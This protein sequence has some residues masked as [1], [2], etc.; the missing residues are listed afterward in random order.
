MQHIVKIFIIA[1]FLYAL[2]GG[3]AKLKYRIYIYL[4]K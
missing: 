2:F 4:Y 1:N 3:I